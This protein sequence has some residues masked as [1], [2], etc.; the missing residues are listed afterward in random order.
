MTT[1]SKPQPYRP[2]GI[3]YTQFLLNFDVDENN[4]LI[5][6]E[7]KTLGNGCKGNINSLNFTIQNKK[8]KDAI[9]DL[10]EIAKMGTC[11][12]NTSCANEL[13]KALNE[14]LLVHSGV[15]ISQLPSKRK[16]PITDI[17]MSLYN[18]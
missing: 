7:V 3:C 13:S 5:C 1:K 8:A 12:N 18:K 11:K 6:R 10:E 17:G 16:S 9:K 2:Q 15:D 14:A 4:E